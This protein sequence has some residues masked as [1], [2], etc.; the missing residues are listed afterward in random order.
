MIVRC[1]T[2][3]IIIYV[4][5]RLMNLPKQFDIEVMHVFLIFNL[6]PL[7]TKLTMR[8]IVFFVAIFFIFIYS[9]TC[10]L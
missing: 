9:L 8:F 2:T 6:S 3:L 4:N 7:G 10:D 1:V 5:I